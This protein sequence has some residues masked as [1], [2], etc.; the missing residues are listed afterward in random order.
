MATPTLKMSIFNGYTPKLVCV[1]ASLIAPAHPGLA[2][3]VPK[4]AML[5]PFHPGGSFAVMDPGAAEHCRCSW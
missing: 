3:L 4:A 2:S 5:L 1:A